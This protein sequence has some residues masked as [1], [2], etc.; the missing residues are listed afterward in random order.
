[1]KEDCRSSC[2]IRRN[3]EIKSPANVEMKLATQDVRF[4]ETSKVEA[5]LSKRI[6]IL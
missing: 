1:M 5:P 4:M 2:D 6:G 3:K